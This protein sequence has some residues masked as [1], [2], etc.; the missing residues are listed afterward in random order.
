MY[1]PSV[2]LS[3]GMSKLGR[4]GA[5]LVYHSRISLMG[6]IYFFSFS[7]EAQQ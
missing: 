1:L 6:Q 7:E 4:K 5:K 3:A 2:W